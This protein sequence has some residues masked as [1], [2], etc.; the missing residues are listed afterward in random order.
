MSCGKPEGPRFQIGEWY[1][2]CPHPDR[3]G[4]WYACRYDARSRRTRRRS[5]K[6]A[7]FEQAKIELA[8]LV[9]AAPQGGRAGQSAPANSEVMTL[10]VLNAYREDRGVLLASGDLVDRALVLFSDYLEAADALAAPV[11]FWTPARQL[12][13]AKW[14][15]DSHGHSPAYLARLFN[16]MRS[17]FI[18]ATRVKLRADPAGGTIEAALIA[19]APAIIARQ[20]AIAAH[21]GIAARK[22]RRKT[23]ALEE[24]APVLDSIQS[25]HLFRFAILSL[26]TWARPQAVIDFDPA[27]Q[28]DWH[29][30]TLDLAP[31]E[32]RP[33]KKRRPL[34][35]LTQCIADWIL[36][37][38][39]ADAGAPLLRYKRQRVGTT[40]QA[41]RRI[42]RELGIDGFSQYSFR[43][44]MADQ[45]RMLF[46]R[47]PREQRSRWLGHVVRDGS[48]TTEHYEGQDPLALAD[49]ALATD[50][51]LALLAERCRRPLFAIE[52]RLNRSDLDAIG[53]RA[54]P[55]NAVK[56]RKDGGRD[57]D[58][59]CDPY[60]VKVVALEDFR[61]KSTKKRA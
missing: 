39:Q 18:D 46:R 8:A 44:F 23:L 47:V 53:A 11:S 26:C 19:A 40:K 50:C 54:M 37:W 52:V 58:R 10:A 29:G 13:C 28:I 51:I 7:D 55:K 2:D 5:L 57:R 61:A 24:M 31:P 35:P 49:V 9:A 59:T 56:S 4:A 15:R 60:H 45:C 25:E 38:Q 42:G 32:W 33:T 27:A 17:A 22:P 43:H 34:Q 16:I 41:W 12:D 21:L 1:L 6:T 20:D 14:L 36:T 30:L 3:G 48:R